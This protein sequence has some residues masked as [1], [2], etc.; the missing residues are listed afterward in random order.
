VTTRRPG[1]A[2]LA[3]LWLI[4]AIAAVSVQ[5]GLAARERRLLGLAGADRARE[6][7]VAAGALATMQARMD[8]DLRNRAVGRGAAALRSSDPWLDVDSIYS[9][10]IAIDSIPVQVI[11]KDLGTML[12]LNQANNEVELRTFFSFVLGNYT[13]AD[14][15]AQS[16]MDWRDIDETPRVLGA[17]REQ[18]LKDD[19]LALPT[20]GPFRDV[21]DLINIRGMTP[22][23]LELIRPYITTYG[24]GATG[25]GTIRVNI[26]SAPEVVLRA[27]PGMTDAI[28]LQIMSQRSQGRRIESVQQVINAAS[29]GASGAQ[30]Q[31]NQRTQEALS[32]R[33][34]VDTQN[35]LLTFYVSLIPKAQPTKLVALITRG[36]NNATLTW[37]LW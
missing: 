15:L 1:I 27:L 14:Q 37:Q 9:G 10:T 36:G 3:A 8:Y 31:Q 4:V 30:Q 21:D 13:A 11:A 23:V 32:N 25:T 35:V 6:R 28:L 19:L 18:Y 7:A 5:F 20:N 24:T 26:N 34:S 17:E 33:T 2:L 12:F 22:E 29:R 16:I